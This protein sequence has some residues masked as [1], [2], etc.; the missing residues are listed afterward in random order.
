MSHV[1]KILA[2]I[3]CLL[4]GLVSMPAW[5]ANTL[6]SSQ[7]L[8]PDGDNLR[9]EIEFNQ[10]MNFLSYFPK[11]RGTQLEIRMRPILVAPAS[12]MN[13]IIKDELLV[14]RRADNPVR[15]V[16]YEQDSTG[17][18]LLTVQFN[19]EIQFVVEPV[20]DQRI[21]NIILVNAALGSKTTT[22]GKNTDSDLPIYVINLQTETQPI[23]A[24]AQPML[25]NFRP[26]Y[27][28]YTISSSNGRETQYHLRLGYF[29]SVKLAAE[30]AKR[31]KPFYPNAWVDRVTPQYR[32]S[33]ENWFLQ[34]GF[35]P[36]HSTQNFRVKETIV[37][38]QPPST[39]SAAN[40]AIGTIAAAG[41]G[42]AK[43]TPGIAPSITTP[44]G[45]V[46]IT[47]A[48]TETPDIPPAGTT[49]ED[50]TTAAAAA[51]TPAATAAPTPSADSDTDS[52]LMTTAK[53]A[54]VDKDYHKAG[55][56]LTHILQDPNSTEHQEAQELLGLAYERRGL[57]AQARAEYEK[58]LKAYP[59]GTD[60]DR[61]KQRLTG[62][63]TAKSA[64]VEKLKADTT[65]NAANGAAPGWGFFGNLSQYY[66]YQQVSTDITA[67]QTTDNSVSTGLVL[68]GRKRGAD[69]D[70]RIDFAGNYF[71]NLLDK[72]T[73]N[74]SSNATIYSMFYDLSDKSDD[75]SMRLGRQTHSSDG[76]LTRFDGV[77]F[78]K[79]IGLHQKLSL[80]AGSPVD[81]T[82]SDS[83]NTDRVFYAV[84]MKF[85][86]LLK[87]LDT[88]FY[89]MHQNNDGLTDR[90]ALGNET[91][92][93][94][95]NTTMYFMYDYDV[96]YKQTNLATFIGNWRTAD[97][98]SIN[99]TA[100]YRNSPL[101]TTTNALIGQPVTTLEQLQ[102]IF[103]LPE[104]QQ[105]ARD[106]TGVFHSLSLS[107]TKTLSPRYQ[108][109]GDIT[110]SSLDGTPASGGVAATPATGNL[111][112]YNLTLIGNNFL[113][114]DDVAVMGA[115]YFTDVAADTIGVNF[116]DRFNLNSRWR[117]NPRLSIDVRSGNDGSERTTITPRINTQWR[118]SRS[119]Q[120]EMEFA[121]QTV[122]YTGS[123]TNTA[124][125]SYK[126]NNYYTYIGYNYNF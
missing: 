52:K 77:T 40:E 110:M 50:A 19:G 112:Y 65:A 59:T 29:H 9:L 100:D 66:R 94:N 31:L 83:V 60:A 57:P 44:S 4:V 71:Y 104:V 25:K 95:Q 79:R 105:L 102:Q 10:P 126:E 103:T 87:N 123:S 89:F 119:W 36:T 84:S 11:Q 70:Q 92:Y 73:P 35:G 115:R 22:A 88:K 107:A 38:T 5:A 33:A 17:N 98:S 32:A 55:N 75:I 6:L 20:R 82:Y 62:L 49:A 69:W 23:N 26:K 18:G 43:S 48:G 39:T 8:S 16:N 1:S 85:E 68:S 27:P 121:Y 45:T 64:P 21:I 34:Q 2:L 30:N 116:S 3:L 41:A 113:V 51:T 76:V 61:V 106:R 13:Q 42:V 12:G 78:N 46:A 54:I 47:T 93:V 108:L 114:A 58:Y 125:P 122:D 56:Y 80:L 37:P 96:F 117:I 97:N 120:L 90:E 101:L 7:K 81:Y 86:S 118:P 99:I 109:N 67:T 15:G 14:E 24:D 124:M 72:T 91:Q 63:L 111:Y 74:N 28:I 53:Q